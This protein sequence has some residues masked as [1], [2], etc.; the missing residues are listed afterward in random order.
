MCIQLV[1]YFLLQNETLL[2][3]ATSARA[4]RDENDILKEKANKAQKMELELETLKEKL[5]DLDFFKQRVGELREDN[6]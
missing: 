3:D 4:L 2:I 6:R 5:K 1:L